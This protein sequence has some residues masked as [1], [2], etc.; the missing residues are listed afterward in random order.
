MRNSIGGAA[1]GL[2]AALV[3]T[4]VWWVNS[5]PHPT[6]VNELPDLA[7]SPL[8]VDAGGA[9]RSG[10]PTVETAWTRLSGHPIVQARPLYHGDRSIEL[11][12]TRDGATTPVGFIRVGPAGAHAWRP[13]QEVA[14]T[15]WVASV[16]DASRK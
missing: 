3:I 5:Q 4:Y 2:L 11:Q 10:S 1:G 9:P 6:P 8:C 12:Y 7:A 15:A 14:T 16:C 13:A